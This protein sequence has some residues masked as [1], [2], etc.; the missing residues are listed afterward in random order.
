MTEA[1]RSGS[2]R[3]PSANSTIWPVRTAP[4]A[5][6]KARAEPSNASGMHSVTTSSAA[7]APKMAKRTVPSSGSTTLVSQA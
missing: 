2:S 6:A 1:C 7:I 4:Y 3:L 5:T